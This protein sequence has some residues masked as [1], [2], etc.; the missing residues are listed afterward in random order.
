MSTGQET[1]PNLLSPLSVG[2]L[3]LPN[4]IIMGSMH[5][6][7]EDHPKTFPAWA[8]YLEERAS[9]GLIVT[10]GISPNA[11][12]RLG[13]GAGALDRPELIQAHQDVTSAVHAKGGRLALQLLHAGRYAAH[14]KAVAPSA[15][16]S[17]I[18]PI[19]PESLSEKEI[20]QT[21]DDFACA[22]G[23]AVEAGY[24]AVEVMGSEGY[25]INQFLAERTNTRS[26]QWGGS[27]QN[28]QRFALRVMESIRA[29]VPRDYPVI[30]RISLIDLVSQGQLWSEVADLAEGLEECGAS[31][32][33]S[34]IGWHEAKVPT[35]I[36]SVPRGAWVAW[37]QRLREHVSVPIIGSNRI[38]DLS[39]AEKLLTQGTCDAVSMSRP[40]LAD[41]HLVRK[42]EARTPYLVNTCIACNQSCLDHVFEQRPVSCLVNPRAGQELRWLRNVT[43]PPRKIS[44][45]GGGPAGMSAAFEAAQQGHEVELFEQGAELG[46]QFLL[47]QRVPGKEEFAETVRYFRESL[48]AANVTVH[49]Q[50]TA[51]KSVFEDADHVIIATG[52]TPRTVDLNLTGEAKVL[53]YP[54]VLSGSPVGESVAIIGAGG[55]GLDVAAYLTKNPSQTVTEWMQ[56]W[57][58]GDGSTPGSLVPPAPTVAPRQI[59]LLQRKPGAPGQGVGKTSVWAH[60]AELK[61]AG[62][63]NISGVTY[64]SYD[65]TYLTFEQGTTPTTLQVDTVIVCAGQ[66]PHQPFDDVLS[67]HPDKVTIIGGAYDASGLNA[68][69]AIRQ[70]AEAIQAL[71]KKLAL[72]KP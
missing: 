70:G 9:C 30:F 29:A 23:Y 35:I 56:T 59:Y 52:V 32:F 47:A 8:A 16:R 67:D 44:V 66:E 28:R 40:L 37:S 60:R 24:D 72:S 12:G 14:A 36:T 5:T 53:T 63:K 58:V 18:S 41:P 61:H 11:A 13:P 39:L 2:S 43:V 69:R 57:G 65:G 50:T 45:I 51:P 46:G 19:I 22:A 6:G 68:A 17:P 48:S 10:G 26:D 31:A 4:R 34:G 71:S 25:L 42:A 62:V 54:Q 49:L 7:L 27:P 33:M 15:I 38:N 20:E 3:T 55:I 64:G 21:I 1:Y